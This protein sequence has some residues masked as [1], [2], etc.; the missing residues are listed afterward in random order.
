VQ[1]P[2]TDPVTFALADGLATARFPEAAGWSA[3]HAARRAVAEHAAWLGALPAE[4]AGRVLGKA[5]S[6]GRAALFHQTVEAGEPELAV[7]L[8]EAA[9]QLGEDEA[10]AAYRDYADL[11]A[12]PAEE[13]VAAVRE[14]MR[15]LP[16]YR[17]SAR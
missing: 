2:L 3:R 7:T 4:E 13:L 14:R 8:T 15:A 16:A 5:L 6:A 12:E 11:R 9:R 17:D 1:S 10:L